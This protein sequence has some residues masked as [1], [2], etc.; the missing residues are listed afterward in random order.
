MNS[1]GNRQLD[2]QNFLVMCL[3]SFF[4]FNYLNF[5]ILQDNNS[6]VFPFPS[7]LSLRLLVQYFSCFLYCN[8]F[9]SKWIMFQLLMSQLSR[10][11]FNFIAFLGQHILQHFLG[12]ISFAHIHNL[13]FDLYFYQYLLKILPIL[14]FLQW[15]FCN[16]KYKLLYQNITFFLR[17]WI[18][19]ILLCLEILVIIEKEE[20]RLHHH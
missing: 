9:F 14:K 7:L 4:N 18:F 8:V 17:F 10:A 5:I 13:S 11:F 16:L 6:P 1:Y 3:S 15:Y 2:W 12:L 19:L 20:K